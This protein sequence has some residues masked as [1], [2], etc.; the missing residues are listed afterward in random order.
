MLEFIGEIFNNESQIIL[1][2]FFV[3][4]LIIISIR[5]VKNTN[6]LQV[7]G[8]LLLSRI[9]I[10]TYI[11]PYLLDYFSGSSLSNSIFFIIYFILDLFTITL[12]VFRLN[13]Y[14]FLSE[15]YLKTYKTITG[16]KNKTVTFM[17]FRT[18]LEIK[19][20]LIYTAYCLINILMATE[21]L[22]RYSFWDRALVVYYSYTPVKIMINFYELFI[23]FKF[24]DLNTRKLKPSRIHISG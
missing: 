10:N 4:L 16:D 23:I 3:F 21:Y 11:G 19:I 13:T 8:I 9:V 2:N 14:I 12:I 20:I 18:I 1:N 24:V 17:Y 5:T 22:V 15:V 7:V 6:L